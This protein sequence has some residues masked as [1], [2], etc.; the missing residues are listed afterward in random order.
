[1][2]AIGHRLLWLIIIVALMGGA[3]RAQQNLDRGK[4]GAKLFAAD[5][6]S[7]HRSPRGLAKGRFSWTLTYFLQRHYTSGHASA[8]ELTAYLQSVDL[9]RAKPAPATRKSRTSPPSLR[10]PAPV[11]R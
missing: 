8:Q 3:A 2:S 4:S 9:P 10:P 6:A 1:M 7:C 11:P 5:C